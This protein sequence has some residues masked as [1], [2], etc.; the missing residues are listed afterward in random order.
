MRFIS[1]DKIFDGEKFLRPESVLVW[2]NGVFVETISSGEIDAGATEK[3]HGILCPGFVNA[4]CHT[5]LSHLRN[6][7]P[8]KTGLPEF[9]KHIL[10][11]R[12]N[13]S[14]EEI[15]EAMLAA[16][17]EMWRNGIVAVGD[18]SN[19]T[20]SL[21]MK[22]RSRIHYHTFVELI[23]L[24]PE[25]SGNIFQS[26][27]ELYGKYAREDLRASLAP[28]APYSTSRELIAMIS[29]WNKERRLPSSIHNEES[30]EELKFFKGE[31]S[32]FNDLYDF[33]KLD[34]SWFKAPKT[35][36]LFY[37]ADALQDAHTMLVHNTFTSYEDVQR[38]KNK[39][40]FW[41]FC[42]NANL[43]IENSLPDY[44]IFAE[45]K[46]LICIG[47][48]SLAS[49]Q[50]LDMISEANI[51]LEKGI[52]NVEDILRA[53]TST[54]ARAVGADAEFG[55]WKPGKSA[56]LNL[57]SEQQNQLKFEKKIF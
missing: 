36:S 6:L 31:K 3:H 4:H 33:L 38:M 14:P 15:H 53:L 18:I 54:G 52:F 11:K 26:G 43:Y 1:A 24:K 16:D 25:A 37:Y 35:S 56:G 22:K 27:V 44:R 48:D 21:E 41:C 7:V 57:I 29:G 50:Q 39:N 17:T 51:I 20:D 8:Q 45:D 10:S 5:E 40:I 30:R 13:F 19:G 23:G 12:N 49:N 34:I 9:G 2:N 55:T 42:P 32:G 47:T 28:H 46:R